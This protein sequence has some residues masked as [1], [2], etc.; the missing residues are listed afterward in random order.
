MK[1]R[2]GFLCILTF[3]Y[4]VL[5][6]KE[7]QAQFQDM[8]FEYLNS[9]N[10]LS[11]N[12]VQCLWRD[13]KSYLWIG[14]LNGL[15]KYDGQKI[16]IYKNNPLQANSIS[17][18]NIKCIYED[19]SHNLWIGTS[20]GLNR[21]NRKTDT[22]KRYIFNSNSN[23]TDFN[24]TQNDDDRIFSVIEDNK[25]FVWCSTLNGLNKWNPKDGSSIKYKIPTQVNQSEANVI[26]SIIKDS[27]GTFWLGTS[28][29]KVWRLN[30]ETL[31]FDSFTDP[32]FGLTLGFY[33]NII[34]DNSGMLW[35]GTDGA[36][37]YSFDT[38]TKKFQQYNTIS[39][40]KGTNGKLIKGLFLDGNR[41]LYISVDLGGINRLDLQSRSFE[42]SL[43][44]ER[45][46]NGLNSDAVMTVY[47]DHEGILY[48][49]TSVAGVNIFNPR[50]YRF[51]T[52]RHSTNYE[53]SLIFN[54]VY[55]FYEDSKG[56]IW[57]GTDGG[58]LSIFDP[59]NHS[60]KNYL[61]NASDPYSISRNAILAITEDKNHDIW[62]GTW[63]GGLNRFDR[64]T[65]KFYHFMP[66]PSQPEAISNANIWD[67]M[68]DKHGNIWIS[69]DWSGIDVF[70]IKKGVIK[71]YRNFRVLGT[72]STLYCPYMINRF[73]R[74]PNGV[75]GFATHKGYYVLDSI[76]GRLKL[77]K[78][79]K[80]YNLSDIYIDKKGNYWAGTI[81]S[82]IIL[83]KPDGVIEKFN[84]SN[85]FPSNSISG[86]LEDDKGNIWVL[87]SSGLAEY[88][89]ESKQF[90]H[91]NFSNGLQGRQF[92]AYARLKAKD[93]TF[94]IGGFN[95][96]NVFH[97][98][99]IKENS[100]TPPVYIN[101]FLIFNE[102]VPIDSLNS[103]L[104][105]SIEETKEIVLSYKQS[106]FSFGF[107]AVNFTYPENA[108][109]AYK[110]EGYDQ[111]WNY[112][113]ASRRFVSY[114]NLNPG[115]YT[116]MVKATNNDRV[117]NET[118]TCIQISI[119]PPFW[120]T[121]WFELLTA[122]LIAGSVISLYRIRIN[123]LKHQRHILEQ[124]VKDRTAE[125]QEVNTTLEEKQEE[126]I[127]QNESILLQRDDLEFKN[128]EL[129]DKNQEIVHITNLLHESDQAK[130]RFFTNI[131]HDLRTPLTLIIGYIESIGASISNNKVLKDPLTIITN[132]ANRLLRLV[133][134]LLDFQ[135]IDNESIKLQPEYHDIVLFINTIFAD[136]NVRAEKQK[137]GYTMVSE[138]DH[139]L[140]WFDPD[141][142][143]KILFNLLSNAFKF[144]PSKGKITL[145]L[146]FG[147]LT[148]SDQSDPDQLTIRVTDSGVGIQIEN[149]NK[150]FDRFYQADN[151]M[152]S[153]NAGSGI[154]LALTKHLVEIH[155]GTIKVKSEPQIGSCF[156]V[157][158][159]IGKSLEVSSIKT[160][161]TSLIQI[162]E[163]SQLDSYDKIALIPSEE[164][165]RSTI[166]V[167]E[168]NDELRRFICDELLFK[169]RVIEAGD[170]KEGV[171]LA[172][173]EQPDLVISD[174]M[175]PY[176]NGFEMCEKL[177]LEWQTSH[178]PIIIL[179]A[180]TDEESF[181]HGIEIGADAYIRKPFHLKHLFIQIENILTNRR[182]LF[183]KFNKLPLVGLEINSKN[184]D[185]NDFITKLHTVIEDHLD[186]NEFGVEGLANGVN[187][188]KSQLYKKIFSILNISAGELIRTVRLKKA[189]VF[190][191]EHNNTVSE[192]AF[193]VGF[194]DRPQFSRSFTNLFG[195]SP[196][197]YQTQ[198]K[199][200]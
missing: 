136:F 35:I 188:S 12:R 108:I 132:N 58:G 9:D 69:Y 64:K 129:E 119:T 139:L 160:K 161:G 135:K 90:I 68:T 115:S 130:I 23:N 17:N 49:G 36:G 81:N 54:A 191:L 51:K 194:A 186:D 42:Y 192:V 146:E 85:G 61:Y 5:S 74:Q 62:L 145:E 172:N 114:T 97:P 31:Q 86:F 180:K 52:Y 78:S 76:S 150:I 7:S 158:L 124:K 73:I 50:K 24:N 2:S 1:N 79:L 200:L 109:Y 152:I 33:K 173:T 28:D 87:T 195:M 92:S 165:E 138:R 48:I 175:M 189:A 154:G 162:N 193:M 55:K 21:Y 149:L 117:W 131:S 91:F 159:S 155:L 8:K 199:D 25:G 18:N 88:K 116:F 187:M 67:L 40:G 104:K 164:V 134:Q 6:V 20:V 169:Y 95:G 47:K 41:Y 15:N 168:D 56:L 102:S 27:N 156:E 22:F 45:K 125:L 19:R 163:S 171:E 16:T 99:D 122:L 197:Q 34:L 190:L 103:P 142:L 29:N 147:F 84:E 14:T 141:K 94:Y 93:G 43:M 121:W 32:I 44:N 98:E 72:D 178:I 157:M 177:K 111:K 126:I 30:P 96:I 66:N 181:Y 183:D 151:S 112:T 198:D 75:L 11:E 53:N 137:I 38:G 140:T 174:V 57:I 110:M 13:N 170:G 70:D 100:Y 167:V 127:S 143:D 148:P 196:K 185:D 39:D 106:V 176:M 80:D 46:E 59:V 83:V 60:F 89:F 179:T 77:V 118:P 123:Q 113:N 4:L 37:L 63:G 26:N 82:G 10:G 144:T 184:S 101:E 65:G 182:K 3:I 153:K 120:R 107:T 128:N 71:K 166:L 133:N 105:Q